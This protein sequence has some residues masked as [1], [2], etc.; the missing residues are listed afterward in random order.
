MLKMRK[1]APNNKKGYILR[2]RQSG[3]FKGISMTLALSLIF[4]MIQP[5]VSWAL[6]EGPSQPEVQSFE[7]IGTTQMVDL[8][9]GDFNYNI[10]L[11]NLPGP[12]GGYPVN[13]AY[14]AGVSMDD[15][16]S[17]VGL[18]WNLNVGAL[19]RNMRG[20]PD[21]FMSVEDNLASNSGLSMAD[22]NYDHLNVKSDMKQSWTLGVSGS[23]KAKLFGGEA[24]PSVGLSASIYY[25]NYRGV[26]VTLEPSL[27][28]GK[29]DNFSLGISL[30]SENGLG[31]TS[32]FGT[33]AEASC[34]R[35]V[36]SLSLNFDGNL[37]LDYSLQNTHDVGTNPDGTTIWKGGIGGFSSSISFAQ[38]SYTTSYSQNVNHYNTS[39]SF[40]LATTAFP[41][42][43]VGGSMG[44]NFSTQDYSDIDKFGRNVLVV[45]YD[46]LGNASITDKYSRD[47]SR[48]ADGTI[49]K[50]SVLLSPSNY[51]YDTYTSSGQGILGAFRARRNDIGRTFDPKKFD[52]SFGASFGVEADAGSSTGFQ[53]NS[54]GANFG[55]S[56]QGPWNRKNE[57]Y[58]NNDTEEYDFL[59]PDY[60]CLNCNSNIPTDLNTY[61]H[62]ENL[63]YQAHG[64]QTIMVDSDLSYLG[65]LTL[66][67]V[68]LKPKNSD[69]VTGGKR[70]V[71]SAVNFDNNGHSEDDRFVR[72]T[73]I[74][75]LKN[76][77]V[78]RLG[79]FDISFYGKNANL[80]QEP[81]QTLN[82]T[83]RGTVNIENHKAG[84]KVLNEQG[85]YYVYGLPA[86]NKTEVENLFSVKEPN[87]NPSDVDQVSFTTHSGEVDYKLKNETVGI[88]DK[89]HKYISKTTKSPYAHSYLLTS[90]QGAD[91]VDVLNDGPSDD[92]L[93]YWVKFDYS[94]H[95]TDYKWRSP[96]EYNKANYNEGALYH[97]DDD[98]ASYQYG[99]KEIWY[100]ARMETKSHVAIFITKTDRK[101]NAEADGE[102]DNTSP[103]DDNGVYLDKI[104][105]YDKET[106]RKIQNGGSESDNLPLQTVH[107]D[108]SY[109]LCKGALN[110]NPSPSVLESGKLTLKSVWFT[111][112]GSTRGEK[113]KY[114]FDYDVHK[115]NGVINNSDE[116]GLNDRNPNYRQNSYDPWGSYSPRSSS[117]DF[118]KHFPYT[119]QF[120]QEWNDAMSYSSNDENDLSR[121]ETK[122]M[123]DAHASA[124]CLDRITLPSGG[125]INIKY[126]SDD[127]SHVQHKVANQ[128]FKITKVNDQSVNDYDL[129]S[130]NDDF[131]NINSRN[132]EKSRRV[133]FKL[134]YPIDPA[135]TPVQAAEKVYEKYVEPMI[136]DESGQRN[137]YFKARTELIPGVPDGIADYI[138]GYLPLE[139]PTFDSNASTNQDD[140]NYGISSN[141]KNGFVTIKA[142]L[143]KKK[144]SQ[145]ELQYFSEYHPMALTAWT[146]LQTDAQELLMN[147]NSFTGSFTGSDLNSDN[148]KG[149]AL[150]LVNFIPQLKASFGN[151]RK[152]CKDKKFARRI[153]LSK[154]CIRLASPDKIK[155]GG[156]H[157][158]SEIS[159]KDNWSTDTN[160]SDRSYGQHFDYTI[161]EDGVVVSS[162]GVAQYEPQAGGD[163]NALK[164]P[165]YFQGRSYA[166]TQNNLFS[167]AP[168]NEALF[169]GAQ[170]GYRQVEVTTLNTDRQ[171]KSSPSGNAVGRTSGI[172][173]HEFY[174][175]KDFPTMVSYTKLSEELN[176]KDVFNP[177][178]PI[179]FVGTIKRNYFHG[180]QAYL[181]ETNDMHGK[182]KGVKTF[183]LNNYQINSSP[184]T[185]SSY[186]YQSKP[187]TYQ[188]EMVQKLDNYVNVIPNDGSNEIDGTQRLMGVQV[189]LFTD[190]R[191]S[192]NL[193]STLGVDWGLEASTILG[194]PLP[195]FW[196]TASNH[197][198]MFRTYVTN[199]VVHR[200]GILKKTKSRDLQTVN[201]SEILAYDEKS[202]IPLLSKVKNEF[203]DDFYSYSI[204]AYY[205]YD[206]MGHAYRNI[207]YTF[208]L[209]IGQITPVDPN[210]LEKPFDYENPFDFSIANIEASLLTGSDVVDHLVRGDE[211]IITDVGGGH[212]GN[213]FIR[214]YFLG[215]KYN[216]SGQP[217]SA[218]LQF[219][220][221]WP[222]NTGIETFRFKVIRSGRR[223]HHST[224]AANYLSQG[225][226]TDPQN[227]AADVTLNP[228]ASIEEKVTVQS[229][230]NVLSATASLFKDDWSTT[231]NSIEGTANPFL[232]GNSGIFRPFKS[233][234]YV[235]ARKG[236][237]DMDAN[238]TSENP[239][240]Y[241]DG[242]LENVPEFT[243]DLGN[244]EE[245]V[246]NWEWVN[247]VTRFS[248][249]AY[250]IE[251]VNRLGIYSSALYGY[252]NSLT[253]AVGGNAA[254]HE[255]GV[256]DFET[257]GSNPLPS[258]SGFDF[259]RLLGQTNMNFDNN[260]G[261]GSSIMMEQHN[262]INASMNGSNQ[263]TVTTD[264]DATGFNLSN[265]EL[266]VGLT[267]ISEK[268]LMQNPA[269]INEGFYFNGKHTATMSSNGDNKVVL[270]VKPY[271]EDDN[272]TSNMLQPGTKYTG[273]ISLLQSR[274]NL[275]SESIDVEYVSSKSHTGD[276]SM[277][278]NA[279]S[280]FDQ[281][282]LKMIANKKY[283]MSFW[284]SKENT[285]VPSFEPGKY[286]NSSS[287]FYQLGRM[288]GGTFIQSNIF[289]EKT[290]YSKVIE[291][292]QKVDIEF[293]STMDNPIL[294]LKLMPVA[295]QSIYIDDVRFSPKTGGI[296]T[297]VYDPNRF[298]LRASLNVDNYATFFYYDEE[299]N[300]T[301]KEQETEEGIYTITESRGHVSEE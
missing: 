164:Y 235:G 91:Y 84:F 231:I 141:G 268:S 140:Y 259:K 138:S 115:V 168:V 265:F 125:E 179:P 99:E 205:H 37:S 18:G 24:I 36:H 300:L 126:E 38:P 195:K 117:Y 178:I 263:L 89:S 230:R 221:P 182:P 245:Y 264:I 68:K 98:K 190:Q 165:I 57:L 31:L 1:T 274:N 209:N 215:W 183:E 176:T 250:E 258:S 129:Y 52:E 16:A 217:I 62:Q 101:D 71:D 172:T 290:T 15:E 77:E 35:N 173:R 10:P 6:T 116:Y 273:K 261:S 186:E 19:V 97:S 14:H 298:W 120:N 60:G 253:I 249:D 159:I 79:E 194:I 107:F 27:G 49:T 56:K 279:E 248:P 288:T 229:Y 284:I 216:G 204:P 247:E 255:L 214:A 177:T 70:K 90:V 4:E 283:V 257:S 163:E 30:D 208:D 185:E 286:G 104:K 296:T 103:S 287:E 7:P 282:A 82:R 188:G 266:N 152:Y 219:I 181:I 48:G 291:G 8:F 119:N 137:L 121:K 94:R 2:L 262:I 189:D 108:Y 143:K 226:I 86:Y 88:A 180:T 113:S 207:N 42:G 58:S 155:Y 47:F 281:P 85:S 151:I 46:Q 278:V 149:K 239:R 26:G 44:V 112:L 80:Y 251:N 75:E 154:S 252:D 61:G 223:N 41:F 269:M 147:P 133:Y 21:E 175:S 81:G 45:G 95:A 28:I 272:E 196:V 43:E 100:M 297:Y 156:G 201:E 63:Y 106:Y 11:F 139:E 234:T 29:S 191:Q 124:W 242:I 285:K 260:H 146:Y 96:Y 289:I 111:S 184:I 206:R 127:Y 170:V 51:S 66:A 17:W 171:V 148:F 123:R 135:T 114:K 276:K 224:M 65:G 23:T 64:E 237:A 192:K 132:D 72:N 32:R 136:Q 55:W 244:I 270:T 22:N 277:K 294:A 174:T 69:G 109:E 225:L 122:Q 33:S 93:G 220:N 161:K 227:Q 199:K 271:L 25:N 275:S 128:M 243:W 213:K 92:D 240:L 228:L 246:S 200:S 295:S 74:H 301:I 145:G 193:S 142:A 78:D 267:L 118:E 236:Y 67:S 232:S 102:I 144:N 202:G 198:S 83:T 210:D 59:N 39:I 256:C 34:A 187:I 105:I 254:E 76:K 20:L 157:R 293:Y 241:S 73:L 3:T 167:E 110:N 203:G 169:P 158:V 197:K 162:S 280:I 212:I 134:E 222:S 153:D 211:L 53:L 9:T 233:Y 50:E 150:D 13:L 299:G 166:F 54:V 292:W 218:M 87:A 130:Y 131:Y 160:E 5:S 40:L 238:N 12:N